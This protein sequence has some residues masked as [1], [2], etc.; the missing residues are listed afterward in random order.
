M[1]RTVR[2]WIRFSVVLA[3][4][5][6]IVA[7]LAEGQESHDSKPKVSEQPLNGEQLAIYKI[8]LH[9]W[10]DDG[11][12]PFNLGVETVPLELDGPSGGESC[13]KDLELESASP[14][15]VHRFRIED[16]AQMGSGKI[17]L[18]DPDEQGKDVAKNDPEN[19][20]RKGASVDDA[21]RNAFA[22]GLVTLERD[23][24]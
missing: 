6:M 21:V 5:S 16:V 20:M 17:V 19:T 24:L 7:G 14:V 22:H 11:K 3:L 1:W 12:E 8:V 13:A 2:A 9:G 15:V 23:S 10:M 18:V 4:A